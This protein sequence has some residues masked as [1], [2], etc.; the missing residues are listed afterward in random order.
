M[1]NLVLILA[2]ILTAS[3]AS[4]NCGND[5]GNGNGCSGNVGPRGPQGQ[6]GLNGSDGTNGINGTNGTNGTNGINGTNGRDADAKIMPVLDAALR[7]YDGKYVQLQAFNVW[8]LSDKNSRALAGTTEFMAGARVV[9]K[10]GKSYEERRLD[11]LEHKL[12]LK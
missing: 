12:G 10:I 1:R 3:L 9:L 2:V 11:A 5:N 8:H 7:L 4:A 6:P